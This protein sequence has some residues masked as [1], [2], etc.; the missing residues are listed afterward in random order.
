MLLSSL[1][2]QE[3]SR[4]PSFFHNVSE[5][6]TEKSVA[7]LR[8]CVAPIR[9]LG[10]DKPPL[11][12]NLRDYHGFGRDIVPEVKFPVGAEVTMGGF[13][14]DLK[15]F[16]IWPGR[17]QPGTHDME[18]PSFQNVPENAPATMKNM[19]RYCSNRA[20]VKIRYVDRFLQSIA[21]IHQVMVAGIYTKEIYNA[22]AR[23][24]VNVI[25]PPDMTPPA[26]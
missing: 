8:H 17:I 12:F 21:G 1:L 22:T 23:M 2:L 24:N 9:L 15:N 4:K 7:I 19:R 20:E 11:P 26:I 10:S 3:I 18:T 6:D 13:S 5:V 25:A 16:V 14:K